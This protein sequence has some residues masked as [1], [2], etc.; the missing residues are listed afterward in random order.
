PRLPYSATGVP[1]LP[2][3]TASCSHPLLSRAGEHDVE[4]LCPTSF[5]SPWGCDRICSRLQ[6]R[7][8]VRGLHGGGGGNGAAMEK[9]RCS[10]EQRVVP[11]KRPRL[12]PWAVGTP[13]VCQPPSV[14]SQCLVLLH[15]TKSEDL[16]LR[17]GGANQSTA[18]VAVQDLGWLGSEAPG[19][20]RAGACAVGSSCSS[21]QGG[22]GEPSAT[23]CS[24]IHSSKLLLHTS[25]Q[26]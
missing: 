11:L 5:P 7:K 17:I 26:I 9:G 24:R 6:L 16:R 15:H 10:A 25:M 1:S 12:R 19:C 20:R 22:S 14:L 23:S 3:H 4:L 21:L 13:V 8:G 2:P 18:A